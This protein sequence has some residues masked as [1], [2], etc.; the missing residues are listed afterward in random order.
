VTDSHSALALISITQS[1]PELLSKTLFTAA[2]FA[3]KRCSAVESSLG[4]QMFATAGQAFQKPG[5]L[6]VFN[7]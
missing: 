2:T 1:M 6:R 3:F 5:S 4:R 7:L